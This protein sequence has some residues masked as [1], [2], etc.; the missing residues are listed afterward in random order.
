MIYLDANATTPPDPAVIEAML[1]FLSQHYGNASS[2]HAGG[3]FARRAM[4]RARGQVAALIGGE[5]E[6]IIFTSGATES[7][8]AVH[9]SARHTWPDRPLLIIS[10]TEHP[11]TLECAARWQAQGGQVK[12]IP[13]HSDGLLDMEALQ[14]ALVPGQTA[15]VSMLWANNETGVIQPMA[16]IA[17]L[18]HAA[19][20][21]VHADAVQMVG[22]LPV[23]VRSVGVDYL[24]LSGHKMHTPKGIGALFVSHHAPFQPLIIG[25]GQERERRSGTENVPGIVALGK[26]AELA[27]TSPADIQP[28]RDLLEQQLLAALPELEIHSQSAPRLPTTS[29]IHFPGVDAAALLIRLDQKG[30]ACSGGSACHTASLHPSH[31]LEAMGYDAR[32]ASSTLRLSLSRLSTEAEIPQAVQEIIAAVHHLRAQWDPSVVVTM[33]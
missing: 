17:A 15:L 3:R 32:H 23:D 33:A 22:K 4:E 9:L 18:A 20:A 21:L 12:S 28:L 25:G 2:S 30:I 1:P 24:S 6:E 26:A 19:G 29:S 27:R 13:V 16:E 5:A 7:I 14:A 8:N 31:V 10:A 11:A